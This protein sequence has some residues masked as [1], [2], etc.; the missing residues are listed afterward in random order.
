VIDMVDICIRRQVDLAD[1]DKQTLG[2][3]RSSST[4]SGCVQCSRCII[5]WKCKQFISC[6]HFAKLWKLLCNYVP[7]LLLNF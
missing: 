5:S 4:D 7:D 6:Y 2:E 3:I 1:G